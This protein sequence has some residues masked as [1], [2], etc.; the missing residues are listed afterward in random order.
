VNEEILRFKMLGR[1]ERIIPVIING[2]PSDPLR[3]CFPPALRSKIGPDGAPTGECEEPIAADARSQGDGEE[4]AK[5]K[6]IAGLLGVALDEIIRRG[7]RSRKRRNRWLAAIASMFLLLAIGAAGAAAYAWYQLKTNEAFLNATLKTATEI[8][9]TAVTQAEK[10][11]VPRVATLQL[12]AEAEGIF[13]NM[14]RYGRPTPEL[15]YQKA[16][17]LMEFARN[18]GMLGDSN[19]RLVLANEAYQL[20]RELATANANDRTYQRQVSIA[21]M[22]LGDAFVE[23]GKLIEAVRVYQDS[24]AV[25]ER[26]AQADPN[27]VQWK[28]DLAGSYERLGDALVEREGYLDEA[29]RIFR[30][31][32]SISES[33]AQAD[34]NNVQLQQGLSVSYNKAGHAFM[35]QG[36]HTDALTAFDASLAVRERLVKADINNAQ[37]QRDLS[38]SYGNVGDAL[39]AKEQFTEALTAFRNSVETMERLVKSDPSNAA[40]QRDLSVSNSKVGDVFEAQGNLADALTAFRRS[41]VIA[42]QLAKADPSNFRWQ[43]DVSN[44]CEKA[45]GV[46][47]DQGHLDEALTFFREGAATKE[48][49]AKADPGNVAQQF[50]LSMFYIHIGRALA[51]QGHFAEALDNYRSGLTIEEHLID[52]NDSFQPLLA[53]TRGIVGSLYRDMH[54]PVEALAEFRKG[55]KIVASL[56]ERSPDSAKLKND[57]AIFDQDIAGLEH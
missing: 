24:S 51:A 19:K 10:Y 31:A 40:W 7:E 50:D 6:V 4:L 12:L 37:Y 35:A 25:G 54:R 17:M 11:N 22:E 21:L 16:S 2:E 32:L 13:N 43:S 20:L 52:V 29:V 36:H 47:V 1:S 5:Y 26:L 30:K 33:A 45:G 27:N 28:I 9:D 55:R 56:L 42:A 44:Y 8:V 39:L 46:L 15:R 14:A 49:L 34:P 18:Y 57:L 38:V 3:E 41:L 53:M 48:R 23:Q